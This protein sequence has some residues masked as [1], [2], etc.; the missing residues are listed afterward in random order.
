M[1]ISADDISGAVK[2]A[3]PLKRVLMG[4]LEELGLAIA[5]L[6]CNNLLSTVASLCGSTSRTR[7]QNGNVWGETQRDK[8]GNAIV[9]RWRWGC[10][11]RRGTVLGC[12]E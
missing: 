3:W 9:K 11:F 2:I 7:K 10:L 5:E 12:W 1:Q 6:K 8:G 4:N